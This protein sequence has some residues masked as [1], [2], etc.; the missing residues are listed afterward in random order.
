MKQKIIS[1]HQRRPTQEEKEKH[2]EKDKWGFDPMI[3]EFILNDNSR[4]IMFIY[5]NYIDMFEYYAAEK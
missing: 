1:I 3:K 2:F 5:C 4:D